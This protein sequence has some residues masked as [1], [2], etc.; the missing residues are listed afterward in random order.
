MLTASQTSCIMQS[1]ISRVECLVPGCS[2]GCAND[3]Q[4]LQTWSPPGSH[5][6]N[7]ACC[8]VEIDGISRQMQLHHPCMWMCMQTGFAP[9]VCPQIAW[10]TRITRWNGA[11]VKMNL[12][13]MHF[14]F[15]SVDLHFNNYWLQVAK[16]M[17]IGLFYIL[18]LGFN[19]RKTFWEQCFSINMGTIK[20]KGPPMLLNNFY[21]AISRL[22]W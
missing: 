5:S 7:D 14:S 9:T 15:G 3:S 13:E 20:G 6:C 4:Q 21:L 22:L 12:S 2:H 11:L 16:L 10:V 17:V 1:T 19:L 18:R 8:S